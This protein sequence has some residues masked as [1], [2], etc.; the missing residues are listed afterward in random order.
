M[1]F[2]GHATIALWTR[3]EPAFVLGSMLPDFATMASTRLPREAGRGSGPLAEGIALHLRTD[4][5][6]HCA[7]V[8]TGLLQETLDELTALGVPRGAARAVGHIGV[9]MLIDGE[10][11]QAQE[12][13]SAYLD[14][15]H[16]G[17]D[18]AAPFADPESARRFESL[19]KRL[20]TFGPPCDYRE[21]DV[22]LA[23][24][25]RVLAGRP[26]LALDATSSP[27]VR[28]SLPALQRKV[29]TSLPS[30]LESLRDALL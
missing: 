14:A 2:I 21:P 8:F 4:D 17:C 18:L 6:F 27:I 13:Q 23:R 9:E 28:R 25:G 26:R 3:N 11:V 12:V 15:L 19:R 30:L 24:L 7:P 20:L 5:V 29:M 22:V 10:L 16:A 1:N